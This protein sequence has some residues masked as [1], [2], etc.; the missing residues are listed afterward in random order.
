MILSFNINI[1]GFARD[2][3]LYLRELLENIH[4]VSP[5]ICLYGDK[6]GRFLPHA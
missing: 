5:R 1:L 6:L 4:E 2:S 3:E